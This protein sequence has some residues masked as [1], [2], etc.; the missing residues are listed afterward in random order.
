[1]SID[2]FIQ[3]DQMR[4]IELGETY[5]QLELV[6]MTMVTVKRGHNNSKKPLIINLLFTQKIT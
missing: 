5:R 3:V 1:M 4:Q 2:Y 6:I